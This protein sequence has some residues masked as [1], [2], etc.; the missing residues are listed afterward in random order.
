MS[1]PRPAFYNNPNVRAA[2]Y[3]LA[4]LAAVLWA[5]YELVTNAH[6]NLTNRRIAT[7]FGFLDNTAGFAVN[8]SLI[9]YSESDS[10]ARVFVVGL[11]NTLLVSI[12]GIALATVL[13]FLVGIAR[14]SSNWLVAR[15]AG[16]YVELLRNLP[17]LFQILFWYLAVLGLLPGPR[18]SL[19]IGLA[20]LVDGLAGGLDSMGLFATAAQRLHDVAASTG[21]PSIY[22]NNRGLFVPKPVLLD[23]WQ[24]FAA[25]L[26][27]AVVASIIIAIWARRRQQKTGRRIP[28]G[29]IALT[30]IFGVPLVMARAHGVPVTLD[31]PALRGFNFAGGLRVLPEFVALLVALSTY[32]AAYIAEIVRAGILAVSGGQ[33]EA[34]ASLGLRRGLALRLVVIPQALR[35]IIPPL[36]SQYVNLTKNSSLAVAVGYPDLVAVFAGTA[37]NQTG[38]AIE[39]LVITMAVYLFLSL[40]TSALMNWYNARL[41]LVER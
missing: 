27:L 30:L 11:L 1:A 35:L 24:P 31:M 5:G 26:G 15:V 10:Y 28:A 36:T 21:E 41:G 19:M 39:I 12:I 13:G 32:T 9:A 3:Q 38:Q 18:Q 16:A 7:G 17:L 33:I 22:L 34:A 4:L 29:W 8:Q 14:L 40:V 23:D 25:A 37:L 6:E 20:P 2:I